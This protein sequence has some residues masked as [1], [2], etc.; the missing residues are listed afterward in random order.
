MSPP[1]GGWSLARL[2]LKRPVTATMFFVTLLLLGM[3]AAVRIP[4]AFFPEFDAPF[5]YV[6]MPYPGSTP[7][8]VEQT[9]VRPVE[10][11][12]STLSGVKRIQS[13]ARADGAG[14]GVQFAWGRN[15]NVLASEARD[16]LDAIRG[17]LP[18]DL[19]FYR[20]VKFSSSDQP[21]LRVRF[22]SERD[23][24]DAWGLLND[25]VKRRLERL[26]G[27]ARVELSSIAP[28]E[29]EVAIDSD[30][31]TA[32]GIGL[33]ELAKTLQ[34]AN[35]SL[36]AGEIDDGTRRLRVQPVGEISDLDVLRNLVVAPNGMRL[37]EIADVRLQGSRLDY[38]RR[39]EGRTA[40]GIDLW[41]ERDANLVEVARS[42]H[43]ELAVIGAQP[44]FQGIEF[45]TIQDQASGVTSSLTD[46]AKAGALGSALAILVLFFFL[47]HWMSTLMVAVAIPICFVI[48]LGAMY[49][50]GTTLNI[51]SMMGLLLAIGLL[52]D[53][54]VVVVESIYQKREKY[55]DDPVRCAIEGTRGVQ[56]AI[57]AG[58]LTSIIVFLPNLFGE[59]NEIS[60]FF[61]EIA[62]TI[63][64]ALLASWLVAVSLI[65]MISARIKAP[66]KVA[67]GTGLIGR[68]QDR[69][70]RGLRWSLRHRGVTL[71]ALG[72]L[73]LSSCVPFG[74]IQQNTDMF[75][76]NPARE[77]E[78]YF[79]WR[80]SYSL[81]QMSGEVG[82]IEA[83]LD[84]NRERFQ[85]RQVYSWFSEQGW[86]G[87]RVSLQEQGSG[88]RPVGELQQLMR[89]EMPK[90]ATANIGF[91]GE[92][93]G[94]G[95]SEGLRVNLYGDS[96]ETLDE[97]SEE[98]VRVLSQS[99]VLRD[100]RA[101][102]GDV[103]SELRIRVDRDRA[104]LYGFNAQEVATFVGTA[105]R[106]TPLREF[107]YGDRE[108]PM[109][110]RFD[111]GEEPSLEDLSNFMVRAQDGRMVP[112]L[113]MVFADVQP[114]AAQ[115]RR[116]DRRSSL[117]VEINLVDGTTQNDARKAITEALEPIAMPP[118]YRWSFGA[119]FQ[120]SNEALERMMFNTLLALMMV[121]VV[122][123]ALFESMLFPVAIISSIV[124]SYFGMFW[125]F[126][127]TG[128]TFSIM[129]FI[130][131][132]VL[133]GIVVNNGIV[134]VEHINSLRRDGLERIDALVSGSRERL[135]PILMTM[136][137]T[138]LGMLPLCIA[139]AQVGG[140]GPPYYP[141]ARAIVG[142]LLFS[143]IASLAFLPTIYAVLDDF[144]LWL[145]RQW[146][147]AAIVV[148][149]KPA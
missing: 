77:F 72:C 40:I 37:G 121:V 146:S 12:M 108:I 116:E 119:D 83:F 90:L 47:R 4:L 5:L 14:V 127:V 92:G 93:G 144:S 79:Q 30:R 29:V 102:R 89:D 120:R 10:E 75:P 60:L 136:G 95:G 113:A 104:A 149:R 13:T 73:V 61:G 65:P 84:E 31:V 82:K 7:E 16:R 105:I 115:I 145:K 53:N 103:S 50:F 117:A 91:R 49:F 129:A 52:V 9:L 46:L 132:I 141:M 2:S 128:T 55:P 76:Q 133:M 74:Y 123:A 25:E 142:G 118:G 135:R 59:R 35:F 97:L 71:V 125:F 23:L 96:S 48:T 63:T 26:P 114:G 6:D 94:G 28:P 39:L 137:T 100:V 143:T 134:M 44:D 15:I 27:V 107:R 98:V 106:G 68:L 109:W 41:K 124:F 33:N 17:D 88:L 112:L 148:A 57:S 54:A 19:Q 8:E 21:V 64:I 43:A 45:I 32:A 56:L 131:L 81:E 42:V 85:I 147:D 80:G 78:M 20:V 122:M 99:D 110:V 51:I 87:V 70:A 22:A 58:T 101:D 130:G 24:S 11:V 36:S 34:E 3:I 62:L 69:Y 66:P 1:D 38:R 18:S 111:S 126:M 138:V 67:A 139:G 86:G 140:D